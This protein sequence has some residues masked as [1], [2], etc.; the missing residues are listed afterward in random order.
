MHVRRGD[1]FFVLCGTSRSD[2][3]VFPGRQPADGR[4]LIVRTAPGPARRRNHG[5]KTM[6]SNI[7]RSAFAVALAIGMLAALSSPSS[8]ALSSADRKDA[9]VAAVQA[10]EQATVAA[11]SA[12]QPAPAVAPAAAPSPAKVAAT[13]AATNAVA[14]P[15]AV[16]ARKASAPKITP[17]RIA[18]AP[19]FRYP[20][21]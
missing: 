10:P 19:R 17:R 8:A 16:Q 14:A 11:V 15:A 21:H 20:C 2:T 4:C 12:Q 18:S 1:Q 7:S 13:A 6:T 3:P 9:A 5:L